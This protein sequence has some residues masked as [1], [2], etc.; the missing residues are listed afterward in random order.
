MAVT[1]RRESK[2]KAD[3][4]ADLGLSN[5]DLIEMYRLVAL[6]RAVDERMW[7]LNRAGPDPVRDQ[8]PGP[9]GRAGRDRLGVRE[10]QG[11]DRA[12]LPL[13]R[14]V[15]DLRDERARHPDRA[16]RHGKRPVVGRPPDAGPLRQPRAQHRVRLVAG[17]DPAAARRR[18]RPRGQD[19]QDRPGGDDHD[20][21]RFV[22]PGRRPR[23]AQLRG[24]PQAA[25]RV[26]GREQRLRD[27]R[28]GGD[29]GLGRQR[30]RP[31]ERLRHPRRR[32]RRVRRACLLSAR[33]ATRSPA[34]GP[35]TGPTPD[36]GEGDPPDRPF[37]GRPADQVPLGRRARRGARQRRAA[38]VP[39]AAPRCRRPDRRDRGEPGRRDQGDRRRGDRLRRGAARPR[40]SGATRYV[41]ADPEG[42]GGTR[43]DAAPHVH[44]RHPRDARRRDAARSDGHRAR[45]GRRQEG[46]RVP[47]DGRAVGRVW[48]RTRDRHA[49]HRVDDRGHLDRR[50]RQRPPTRGRDP[51]RRLH[52]PGVQPDR[53]RGGP[54]A[55]SLEQ[56]VWRA[57][58]DPGA[59]RRRRP[60]GA[61]P[62]AVGRGVLHPRARA[63]GRRAVHAARRARAAPVVDPRPGPGAL[64]RAQEDVPLGSRRRPGHG[65]HGARSARPR[66]RIPGR[67]SR[68]S[69][70]G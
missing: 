37:L 47:R 3:L 68:S 1:K 50:R 11:L 31:G 48:R 59:V 52:L 69:P 42:A 34:R 56:R 25:V 17:R 19:P 27:Q 26:R 44:R 65:L 40:P 12:V 61:L 45:R 35:A 43:A 4:G 6:A 67:R 64:L 13:D 15:S 39:G 66:S 57:D 5:A 53:V 30:G 16:V 49:A 22:E 54:D 21:R 8:R 41:Y 70:T 23:G 29:A 36:R 63:Q 14:D 20:G 9:R 32:R 55:L 28:A 58:D 46:R 33:R 51:V 62:L 10:G 18:D 60:R 38:P 7:I 24:H 2:A